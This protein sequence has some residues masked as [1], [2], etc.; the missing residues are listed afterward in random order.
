MDN[1]QKYLLNSETNIVSKN[2]KTDVYITPRKRRRLP[3]WFLPV[4]IIVV[5]SLVLL[6]TVPYLVRIFNPQNE[7]TTN[8]DRVSNAF[9]RESDAVVA[10]KISSVFEK[11]SITSNRLTSVLFNEPLKVLSKESENNFYHVELQDGNRGFVRVEDVSLG[12][13]SLLS[14]DAKY[15]AIVVNGEKVVA[16]DTVNGDIV[17]VAPM[18][19]VLYA[20]YETDQVIRVLL[21]GSQIGWMNRE[22]LILVPINEPIPQ[23]DN[24]QA[25]IFCSSALKF[26]NVA[27]IPGGLGLDGIDLTGVIYLSGITN[28]LTMARNLERQAQ[29][30]RQLSLEKDDSGFPNIGGLKAGDILFFHDVNN[31]KLSSSAIYL[32]DQNIL[33]AEGNDAVIQIISLEDNE[34]LWL[35]LDTARRLFD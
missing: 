27:Y 22:N 11:A 5:V 14:E 20:D 33:Y 17:A 12:T 29:V 2:Q 35:R 24:K 9:I 3:K 34:K 21:P 25:D 19:S 1:D 23:P 28:G 8:S 30:G 16:S 18:G 31:Q 13:D 4:A 6:Y 32:A 7:M 15:K 10:E 26:L